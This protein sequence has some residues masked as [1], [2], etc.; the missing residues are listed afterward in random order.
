MSTANIT[1]V[2]VGD[3]GPNREQPETIFALNAH[4]L[5]DA[6]M[7]F[8]Q[9]EGIL[10]EK[11]VPNFG[12]E[13]LKTASPKN[14]KALTFAGFDVLSFGSNR[15]LA[16]GYD[17]FFDTINV[18]RENGIQVIGAGKN[19]EETRRAAFV[20]KN[21]TRVAFLTYNSIIMEALRH[22]AAGPEKAG[23]NPLRVHT[24]YEPL[25]F[26]EQ[27]GTPVRII[28]L[29]YPEDKERMLE[30]VRAAKSQADIVVVNHHA[31]LD[32]VHA[33][34]AMYQKEL[35]KAAIDAG[36]DLVL[37]EHAHKLRG[38]EVFKGK[39]ICYGLGNF[40]LDPT[41]NE[42]KRRTPWPLDVRQVYG[43]GEVEPGWQTY[44]WPAE[45]RKTMAVKC[46][47]S[48]K[49]VSRVALIPCCINQQAQAEIVTR[50]DG[51]SAEMFAYIEDLCRSQG[52]DTKLSWEGDEVL[53]G[54]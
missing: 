36:A 12:L 28:T 45:S 38:V 2:A 40:A 21:G 39:A 23:V 14:V 33:T 25:G 49:K 3:L 1:M 10:S 52:L 50:K 29:A 19:L 9:L 18:L 54:L 7:A 15:A 42:G 48:G 53:V 46:T 35:A 51:R 31:G 17:A 24:M 20:E 30:D 37:Q 4:L 5:R 16:Y 8:G 13:H 26:P 27:P 44:P 43:L 41:R 6:D 11:G 34:I 22:H 32:Y 47:I